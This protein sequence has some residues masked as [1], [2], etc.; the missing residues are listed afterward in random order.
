MC[1][2]TPGYPTTIII[3][4]SMI[5]G[6]REAKLFRII[7]FKVGFLLIKKQKIYYFTWCHTGRRNTITQLF[8]LRQMRGLTVGQTKSMKK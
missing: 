1:H 3:G 7:K 4:N 8:I 5:A 6:L 2:F